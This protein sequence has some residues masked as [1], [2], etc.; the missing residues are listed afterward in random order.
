M[1]PAVPVRLVMVP[2]VPVRLVIVPFIELNVVM[3]PTPAF[4][5]PLNVVAVITPVT[6]A[7]PTTKRADVGF[8]DPIPRLPET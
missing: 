1:V 7:S 2:E 3:V 8:V 5:F 4:T 6:L